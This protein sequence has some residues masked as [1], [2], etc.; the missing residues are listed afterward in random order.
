MLIPVV[1]GL[2]LAQ[3]LPTTLAQEEPARK[4]QQE[5]PSSEFPVNINLWPV[6]ETRTLPDGNRRHSLWPLFH[7]TTMPQGGVH[8]WHVLNFLTG[9]NYHMFLPLYYSVDEHLGILPPALLKGP[10]YVVAPP[11]LSGQWR[12]SDGDL[13]TWIT[14]LFHLTNTPAGDVRS[15]HVGPYLQGEDYWAIPPLLA[16]SWKEE[17]GGRTTWLT[18]LFH[19]STDAAGNLNAWTLPPFLTWHREFDSG[20][21]ATWVTPLFHWTSDQNGDFVSTHVGPYIQG[22]NYWLLLPLAGSGTSDDETTTATWITP[23]F[24]VTRNWKGDVTDYHIGPYLEG[25]DWWSIPPLLMGGWDHAG[26]GSEMTMGWFFWLRTDNEGLFSNSFCPIYWWERDRHWFVLPLLSGQWSNKETGRSTWVT[27]LF[28]LDT[29]AKEEVQSYHVGP[30]FEGKDYWAVPPLLSWHTRDEDGGDSTWLTPLFHLN[31]DKEG[32]TSSHLFPAYFWERDD[33]WV[34]PPLLSMGWTSGNRDTTTWVTP[35]F[36]WTADDDGFLINMHLGPYMQGRDFWGIPPLLTGGWG[37]QGGGNT[38][39]V[40]PLFHATTDAKGDLES[41]HVGPYFE[42]RKYWALPPLFSWHVRRPDETETTWL[43]PAFHLSADAKGWTSGHL[44]PAVFF[45]RDAYWVAPPLLTGSWTQADGAQTTWVTPAFHVTENPDGDLRSLHVAPLWF[46][47]RE[48]YW[49]ALPLLSG[50]GTHPDGAQTTWITPLFHTTEDVAGN[51]ESF[52]TLPV[53]FWKRDDY[54]IAPFLLSGG[55]TRSDGSYRTWISPLYH[56]DYAADG[57]LLS[58]HAL[59]YFEGPKYHHVVPVFWDWESKD[60]VRHTMFA[61]PVFVRTEEPDGAV[62]SSLPWPFISWRTGRQLDTS[63]GMEIRP[64]V[65][66][67]AG[68]QYEFNFLWR[69][70]SVLREEES[71]RVMLGPLWYSERPNVPD[72]MTSFQIL[73]G[74]FARDCNYD[75]NRY[76]YRLLWLI[77]LGANEMR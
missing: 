70:I 52:H 7:V 27:P 19:R 69:M 62:T 22:K 14:P 68:E 15:I 50:G 53:F 54:W 65:Y 8:S 13:S 72:A 76:R 33:Y 71:T 43:T 23:L 56:D 5:D 45:E 38:T 73:G 3:G 58:R 12:H 11:V 60:Q 17:H 40:T 67:A 34:A 57:S 31:H 75:T 24:H 6:L 30:Y 37:R 49:L 51:L 39:W 28:H 64:F 74:L 26:G 42:G 29:N 18:P 16:A 77:P 35:F 25:K 66:Q 32:A 9:P 36:H 21:S 63:L 61:P 59:T 20:T 44:F 48:K 4:P 47:E 41:L 46:W 10:D 1:V 2:L 55:F